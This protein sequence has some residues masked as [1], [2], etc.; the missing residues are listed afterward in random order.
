MLLPVILAGG[1]GT[2]LWPV[3]REAFP[4]PF[5]TLADGESLLQ[6]T[7]RRALSLPAVNDVLTVTNQAYYF[8]SRDAYANLGSFRNTTWRLDWLL[9]PVGR[10]TG[11]ALISAALHAREHYGEDTIL[12]ILP[13]DHLIENQEKFVKAVNEA[14]FL[15]DQG[16][17]VTFG[18][19][20]SRPETGF[21]YIRQGEKLSEN[22]F[23]IS[24]FLEKPDAQTAAALVSE[25]G[26]FWNSGM[27]CMRVD[28]LLAEFSLH[29]ANLLIQAETCRQSSRLSDIPLTL[30]EK[31]F[32]ALP[33]ISFDFAV[34]EHTDKASVVIAEFD[35]NDIGSWEAMASLGEIDV[36]G[37]C[38][39]GE[40]LNV[41]SRNCYVLGDQRLIATVGVD[42]L[43]IIDT[44]DA[45]LVAHRD[46]AQ[47]VKRVAVEL[48]RRDH[49]LYRF[50]RTV[51]RPWGS[52]TVLEEGERF[53]IKRIVVKPGAS[54]SSQM[55]YHR[56]EHWIV[57]SGT[58]RIMHG[59]NIKLLLT[60]QSTYIEAGVRHRLE[61]PGITPLVMIEVQSGEYLGEDDIVRFE[62]A[63]G[64]T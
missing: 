57:V 13:A 54:L 9:E 2:R 36:D 56:N 23:R 20:P 7:F 63:Y 43:L 29:A 4:K 31:S 14:A 53:K 27:F 45:L 59:E 17:L 30:D 61:N 8:Q 16:Y 18:I 10:N 1:V 40:H 44:P 62:D 22:A 21:G 64:R 11:P 25:G 28:T 15:A 33:D 38:A 12:L 41:D 48:K 24:Q 5:I 19:P 50:H 49:P 35:W 42:D 37:N 6:K 39:D 26:H 32:S 58:A 3:S 51:H 47:E 55:H 34:M 52:Y 46:C 60:N